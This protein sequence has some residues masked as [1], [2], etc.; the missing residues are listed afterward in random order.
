MPVSI[1]GKYRLKQGK[2]K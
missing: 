2:I 1:D